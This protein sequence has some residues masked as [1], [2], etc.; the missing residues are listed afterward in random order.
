MTTT[1]P[2]HLDEVQLSS[3]IDER[4]ESADRWPVEAHLA[5]CPR[6]R[7]RLA[8][9]RATVALLRGLPEIE[10]PRSFQLAETTRRPLALRLAPWSLAAGAL[11]AALFVLLLSADLLSGL[12]GQPPLPRAA[13]TAPAAAPDRTRPAEAPGATAPAEDRSTQ[14]ARSGA[15]QPRA[16]GAGPGDV[17]QAQAPAPPAAT[18]Q[19]T[20]ARPAG[21]TP[22]ATSAP[23]APP[24]PSAV[25]ARQAPAESLLRAGEVATATVASL[26]LLASVVLPLLSRRLR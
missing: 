4:L 15:Q 17:A 9:L 11:A 1:D 8:G 10:P 19:A 16:A 5:D 25:A 12:G 20:P 21:S 13:V 14:A 7:E 23:A 2:H 6:C 26:L 24:A 22:G 3:L 18:P